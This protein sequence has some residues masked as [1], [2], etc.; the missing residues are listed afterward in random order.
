MG[1]AEGKTR[2]RRAQLQAT[3]WEREFVYQTLVTD[4]AIHYFSLRVFQEQIAYLEE[5]LGVYKDKVQ[6]RHDRVHAGLEHEIDLSKSK[7]ELA[8]VEKPLEQTKHGCC[9]EENTLAALLG[10]PASSFKVA[11]GRLPKQIPNLPAIAS[12]IILRRADIKR[13]LAQVSAGRSDVNAALRSY[14]PSFPLTASLGLSTPLISHFFEWQARYWGYAFNAL[15]PLFDG[16]KRKA[17]VKYAKARFSEH[18]A[19]YQK[20]VNRPLKM[21]KMLFQR[22]LQQPPAGSAN[23]SGR[24]ICRYLQPFRRSI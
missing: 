24:C 9:L 13:A 18:F 6:L 14:F 16:G 21:S 23:K 5:T 1:K 15:E 2:E 12:E 10:R 20:P 4:I 22:S 17:D 3:Q 7:Y 11:P 8:L 19:L